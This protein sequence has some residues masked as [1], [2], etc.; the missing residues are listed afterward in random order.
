MLPG[1]LRGRGRDI[2]RVPAAGL[3]LRA[4]SPHGSIRHHL[5]HRRA[6]GLLAVLEPVIERAAHDAR[7]AYL[8]IAKLG[9]VD[10][11]SRRRPRSA[12]GAGS[13]VVF[14]LLR[15]AAVDRFTSD[16]PVPRRL[17]VDAWQPL[18][19]P[20]HRPVRG[21]A[22]IRSSWADLAVCSRAVRLAMS[23]PLRGLQAPR[24]RLGRRQH[25]RGAFDDP[26]RS[27]RGRV[28]GRALSLIALHRSCGG[29]HS[30][31]GADTG[32]RG[33]STRQQAIQQDRACSVSL[34]DRQMSRSDRSRCKGPPTWPLGT[35]QG[36]HLR[37]VII[38]T[39]D[40]DDQRKPR[41]HPFRKQSVRDDG[42]RIVTGGRVMGDIVDALVSPTRSLV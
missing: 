3:A 24:R 1:R 27:V 4:H 7:I 23:W 26:G 13:V 36:H 25:A 6:R 30:Q 42:A 5:A 14:K 15:N 35:E 22:A 12:V 34:A 28:W 33:G 38:G 18:R 32:L 17:F 10:L 11:K 37:A 41:H 39:V 31:S 9:F 21:A 2:E 16:A 8:G 40:F 29:N 19:F 20:A